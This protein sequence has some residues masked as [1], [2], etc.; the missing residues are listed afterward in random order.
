M[1]SLSSIRALLLTVLLAIVLSTSTVIAAGHNHHEH[2]DEH[3]S[4]S[5]NHPG[6]RKIAIIGAGPSGTSAAYW[7]YK[8]QQKLQDVGRGS[9]GFDIHLYEKEERIGGRTKV[10]HPFDDDNHA[11][12]ELGASIFADVNRNMVRFTKVSPSVLDR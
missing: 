4:S 10:V 12:V 6:R 9:D 3:T 11:P 7:L 8:A 2:E 1:P 5:S